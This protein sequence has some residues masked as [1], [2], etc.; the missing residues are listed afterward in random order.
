[1]KY[2]SYNS[3]I[4]IATTLMVNVFNDIII[5]R[6]RH[7]LERDYSKPITLS[8]IVQQDIEVPCIV[9]DRGIILRSLENETGKYKMPLI[10]MEMKD[11]K[12]DQARMFDLHSDIFYQ[13]DDSFSDLEYDNPRYRPKELSKMRA[14]PINITYDIT[15][16]TKY[17]EDLD[18]IISNFSVHFRPDIYLK[19]WH[20]RN[21]TRALESQVTWGHNV[22]FDLPIEYDPTKIFTYKGTSTF[23]IRSWFFY[24]MHATD[25]AVDPSLEPIIDSIKIF[26]NRTDGVDSLGND[27]DVYHD[28][29]IWVFGNIINTPSGITTFKNKQ[30]SFGFWG[31][32]DDQDFVGTDEDQMQNGQYAVNNV[33]AENYAAISG[34]PVISKIGENPN[35]G[36]FISTNDK[37]NNYKQNQYQMYLELDTHNKKNIVEFKNVYFKGSFPESSFFTANPSGDFVFQQFFKSYVDN[38]KAKAVFGDCYNLHPQMNLDYN[39]LTKDLTLSAMH[40]DDTLMMRGFAKFNSKNGCVQEFE[41]KSK[42]VPNADPEKYVRFAFH[43]EYDKEF[44]HLKDKDIVIKQNMR[45]ISDIE[46]NN[47]GYDMVIEDSRFGDEMKKKGLDT[48]RFRS[49]DAIGQAG[50]GDYIYQILANKYLYIVLKISANDPN[51]VEIFDIGPLCPMKYASHHALI[52]EVLIPESR[53]LLGLNFRI[54]I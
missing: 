44:N 26:P 51:D 42:P 48:V 34:D 47:N 45:P 4:L 38:R 17:R 33:F 24:G 49:L 15:I 46:N 27:P 18:Q 13:Q 36:D 40:E 9:G 8:S 12:T 43:R 21:K 32:D 19:W 31:V 16:L 20:P 29:D 30:E 1:M 35:T 37:L 52:Y 25:N 3:E 7:G 14:Q 6:R 22:S 10:I 5:D 11:L 50:D 41:F 28:D 54:S 2:R 53:E 39:I 23:T